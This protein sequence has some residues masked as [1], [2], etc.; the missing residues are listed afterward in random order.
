MSC[1][2]WANFVDSPV[3]SFSKDIFSDECSQ[4]LTSFILPVCAVLHVE[5]TTKITYFWT[6]KW[7]VSE[8]DSSVPMRIIQ[9]CYERR[10][11]VF[12]HLKYNIHFW[13]SE[14]MILFLDL[15]WQFLQRQNLSFYIINVYDIRYI[16]KE[17]PSPVSDQKHSL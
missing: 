6:G 5:A 17:I 8:T 4:G 9:L 10:C 2:P 16:V 13:I 12:L 11:R 1:E 14:Y 15:V 3:S 7:F